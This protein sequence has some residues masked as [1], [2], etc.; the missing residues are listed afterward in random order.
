MIG[1]EMMN[2]LWIS[3][4]KKFIDFFMNWMIFLWIWLRK[5][6]WIFYGYDWENWWIFYGYDWEKIDEYFMGM[7]EK[8]LMNFLL[9][10]LYEKLMNFL[11]GYDC[12]KNLWIFYI[13]IPI[14][15]VDRLKHCTFV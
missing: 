9:I 1:L 12:M 7:I 5:N 14:I 4:D 15:C 8:K 2:F 6:W 10:W 3:L 11:Y 13:I